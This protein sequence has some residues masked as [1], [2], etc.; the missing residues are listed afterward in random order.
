MY[1][2]KSLLN[3]KICDVYNLENQVLEKGG[4]SIEV[5]DKEGKKAILEVPNGHVVEEENEHVE[6]GLRGFYF[7]LF[8]EDII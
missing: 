5:S 1:G 7:N 6:L 4:Y 3:A 8:E 2:K